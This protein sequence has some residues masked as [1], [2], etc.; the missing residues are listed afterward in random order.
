MLS[1]SITIIITNKL[2]RS[3]TFAYSI[4]FFLSTTDKDKDE[5]LIS[6][7]LSSNLTLNQNIPSPDR[8]IDIVIPDLDEPLQQPEL[9]SLS[10]SKLSFSTFSYLFS[11]SK[12]RVSRTFIISLIE[13]FVFFYCD[14][15]IDGDIY[16]I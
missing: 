15:L 5:D 11:M 10:N 2:F 1:K 3:I 13:I 9:D 8:L 4:F 12:E 14:C 7:S 6:S 16:F